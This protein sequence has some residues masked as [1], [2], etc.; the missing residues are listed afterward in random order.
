[1]VNGATFAIAVLLAVGLLIAFGIG[2][3][4]ELRRLGNVA[5]DVGYIAVIQAL[6]AF[7]LVMI[8]TWVTAW[9]S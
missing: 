2:E 8:A 9:P 3:H 1:M 5:R 6:A 7:F 4:V